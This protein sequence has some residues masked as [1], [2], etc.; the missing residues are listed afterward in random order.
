MAK[1]I[2]II[3]IKGGV[4][5]TSCT[6]NL[7][8]ALASQFNKKVLLVD[9][10]FSAP[11][12]GMHFG[13]F[14]PVATL[15]SALQGK[16]P[17]QDTVQEYNENLHII[18]SALEA[19]PIKSP[20]LLKKKLQA[21]K[22]YYDIIL[23]DASPSLNNEILST[24][25]ASDELYVIASPDYPTLSTTMR[26]VKVAKQKKTPITG[27]ILNKVRNKSFE[28]SVEE[29]EKATG[30]PVIG[31]LPDDIKM[32]EAVASTKPMAEHAPN[33]SQTIEF[34]KIAAYMIGEKNYEDNGIIASIRKFFNKNLQKVELNRQ[35]NKE[36]DK[37]K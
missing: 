36:A 5:K 17:I 23:I 27:I 35:I 32:L 14:E 24:M 25:I 1:T 9:A 6:A 20:F 3:A 2:G 26:A 33:A 11:N 4:G 7:G 8:A 15:Q 30:V 34:N 21:L 16:K 22:K 28:L 12:L 31:F 29:I 18:P 13:L 19:N 37:K 10:N